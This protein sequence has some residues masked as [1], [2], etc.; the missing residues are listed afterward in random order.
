MT[1]FSTTST[2]AA[3]LFALSALP[4]AL[5]AQA[6]SAAKSTTTIT[7]AVDPWLVA[8]KKDQS[9]SRIVRANLRAL[10]GALEPY[11]M[12]YANLTDG[13]RVEI[14]RAFDDVLPGQ[15]FTTYRI[16]TPQARAIAYIAL[17]PARGRGERRCEYSRQPDPAPATVQTGE[18]ARPSWC[19]AALDTMSRNA[20]WI[21]TTILSLSRS[22]GA[23]RPK[24]E[25]LDELRSMAERA[26][27]IVVSTPR[28]GCTMG[29]DADALLTSTREV[30]D[31]FAG[32]S[33]PAWMTL[34]SE[35]VQRISKL[36]D[37]V[38]RSLLRCL[39]SR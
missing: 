28:C 23:R 22:G 2:I 25:E 18:P 9:Q 39:S 13:E 4:G 19:D 24:S 36:S 38:E 3:A 14:R 15:R 6:P 32:S 31:A 17:G 35:Q 21:H 11:R 34:R 27:D 33:V 20:A 12:T 5:A 16:N 37:S 7:I 8:W 1:R 29:D 26:R 10:D 30:V